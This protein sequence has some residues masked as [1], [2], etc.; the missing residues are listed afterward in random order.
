MAA[1]LANPVIKIGAVDLTGFCTAA[2][3]TQRYDT[4]ENTVFG[5]VDRKSQ[6]GLGNHEA[7][8]TLYLDYSAS[9]T[10]ATLAPLVGTQT[11]IVAKPA[12]GVDGATNPG[13]TLT[14][15][16]LSELPVLNASLGEL[17]SIDLTFTQG[18]YSVDV[19]P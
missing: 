19:T 5:M 12:S 15:T 2:T 1:Y 6:K 11:T 4:L 17:Q 13:F 8:V 14:D 3:V 9:A 18:T 10:Y 16:L 7:T